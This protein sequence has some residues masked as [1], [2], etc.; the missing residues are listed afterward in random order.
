MGYMVRILKERKDAEFFVL[1]QIGDGST[2]KLWQDPWHPLGILKEAFLETLR[3]NLVCSYEATV[4]NIIHEG[5]WQIP[6]NARSHFPYIATMAENDVEIG[7]DSDHVVWTPSLS[8]TFRL[9]E[10]YEGMRNTKQPI[11]WANRIPRQSFIAW[12]ALKGRLKTLAKLKQ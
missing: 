10:T 4:S 9:K 3:Y 11:D 7:G 1:H 12:M 8:G 6:E 5:A 2:I